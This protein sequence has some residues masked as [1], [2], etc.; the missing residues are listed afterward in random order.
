MN[1]SDTRTLFAAVSLALAVAIP[2]SVAAQDPAGSSTSAEARS[3]SQRS[4]DRGLSVRGSL[5]F[6]ADPTTFLMTLELPWQVNEL[7][8]LGPLFQ[9][10]FSDDEVLFAPSIQTY[11][12][13]RLADFKEIRPYLHV[14]MGLIYLEDNDRSPRDEEDTDFLITTGFGVEYE[15]KENF[16]IGT[17]MLFNAIPSGAIGEKFVFGWQMLQMRTVF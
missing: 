9:L 16:L 1:R 14:G 13:P 12:H 7:V 15:I 4:E 2:S 3:P 17:G 8:S 5:G 6:S 11:L 10:G